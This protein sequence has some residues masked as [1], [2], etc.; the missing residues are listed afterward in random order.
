[1]YSMGPRTFI[2]ILMVVLTTTSGCMFQ[3]GIETLDESLNN[4]VV[5][6]PD[7]AGSQAP[8]GIIDAYP[9]DGINVNFYS[10]VTA[11]V[12]TQQVFGAHSADKWYWVKSIISYFD[13][14]KFFVTEDG[15]QVLISSE[16]NLVE[17]VIFE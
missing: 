4:G 7:N 15:Y 16:D 10:F 8:V 12:P 9:E 11:Y 17:G 2:M 13:L 6:Q 1:M 3:V 5:P 14:S